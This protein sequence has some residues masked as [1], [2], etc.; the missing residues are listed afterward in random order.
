[1]GTRGTVLR[2]SLREFR[3]L[4]TR[5]SWTLLFLVQKL[6]A[7]ATF[8]P[9]TRE[10]KYCAWD[11]RSHFSQGVRYTPGHSRM[12]LGSAKMDWSPLGQPC[13]VR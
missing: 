10:T 8:P 12:F 7:N 4:P 13:W 3:M 9:S 5:G 6:P 11:L 1:M 2:P